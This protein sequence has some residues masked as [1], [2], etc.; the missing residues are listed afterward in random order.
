MNTIGAAHITN[1]KFISEFR[2]VVQAN[3]VRQPAVRPYCSPESRH[4]L[5]LP[6]LSLERSPGT[7][8]LLKLS[9]AL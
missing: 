9:R 6:R 1:Y 7:H 4:E 8:M 5:P 2:D 3:A